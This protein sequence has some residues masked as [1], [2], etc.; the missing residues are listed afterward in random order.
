VTDLDPTKTLLQLPVNATDPCRVT[1][2]VPY[3]R[4]T[5][6]GLA[7]TIIKNRNAGAAIPTAPTVASATFTGTGGSGGGTGPSG[8]NWSFPYWVGIKATFNGT[9]PTAGDYITLYRGGLVMSTYVITAADVSAGH[10]TVYDLT[11]TYP[12]TYQYTATQT[13]QGAGTSV[14]SAA[15]GVTMRAGFTLDPPASLYLAQ[16]AYLAPMNAAITN[17][18][19]GEL[20]PGAVANVTY[21][22]GLSSGSYGGATTV[23]PM[24]Q[25]TTSGNAN[26]GNWNIGWA[27]GWTYVRVKITAP[28]YTDSAVVGGFLL[29]K[30]GF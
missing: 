23:P 29:N 6:R 18:S 20:P 17:Y 10:C 27:S 12:N 4:S 1:T 16:P 25:L 2:F 13:T 15:V 22:T 14:A 8:G 7:V 3:D 9:A 5:G 26:G 28:G 11:A 21:I 24:L 30:I 19:D